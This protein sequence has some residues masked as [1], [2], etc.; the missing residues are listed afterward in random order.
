MNVTPY[1]QEVFTIRPTPRTLGI[2]ARSEVKLVDNT[3]AKKKAFAV[4][5]STPIKVKLGLLSLVDD[6][7]KKPLCLT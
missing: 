2:Q 6:F 4:F 1:D 7:K 3:E 5:C